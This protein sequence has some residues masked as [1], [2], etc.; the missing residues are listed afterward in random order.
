MKHTYVLV[1][2]LLILAKVF[3]TSLVGVQKS[4]LAADSF[5]G[6]SIKVRFSKNVDRSVGQ[7]RVAKGV[8]AYTLGMP[9]S[10]DPPVIEVKPMIPGSAVMSVPLPILE[11]VHPSSVKESAVIISGEHFG[12]EVCVVETEQFLWRL[13]P[14]D[15]PGTPLYVA[16]C[17]H[18]VMRSKFHSQ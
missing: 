17:E 7:N 9:V 1:C 15:S 16:P 13:A 18:L 6:K 10:G 2:S 8:M 5:H 14:L 4:W 11:P 12:K 3:T